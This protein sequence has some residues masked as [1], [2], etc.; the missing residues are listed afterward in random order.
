MSIVF[1]Y[2]PM[3]SATRVH[4]ALEEL[5]VTYDKVKVDLAKG[6]NRK[7]EFLALNPNGKIP[8][9]LIDGQP[10]FESLAMLLYLGE[11]Y[12]VDKGLFPA[13]GPGRIEAF[14][15]MAWGSVSLIET[16]SRFMR[17][18]SE[19]WPAEQRS[20]PAAAAALQE[21]DELLRVLDGALAG[22]QFLLGDAFSIVDCAVAAVVAFVGRLGVDLARHANVSAWTG[23]CMSRPALGRAIA[24]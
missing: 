15:W 7:P 14:K 4:W 1:Y 22:R 11:T 20:A 21:L 2:T 9:M 13:P 19:R 17:N 18:T 3:S 23:R 5:G 8:L 6:D 10:L 12:G 16:G 24:G